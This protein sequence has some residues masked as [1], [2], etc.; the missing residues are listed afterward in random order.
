MNTWNQRV[1]DFRPKE[2]MGGGINALNYHFFRITLV[3]KTTTLKI[4]H[5]PAI[6]YRK[7]F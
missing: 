4:F 2:Y 7:Q 3:S 6:Q 1:Y 5:S